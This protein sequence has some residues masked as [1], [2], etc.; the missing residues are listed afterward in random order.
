MR[1]FTMRVL[2]FSIAIVIGIYEGILFF[3]FG[4]F[5]P[6]GTLSIQVRHIHEQARSELGLP[7]QILIGMS[8]GAV[9][10]LEHEEQQALGI[11]DPNTPLHCVYALW[12]ISSDDHGSVEL[13]KNLWRAEA[14]AQRT[15][16]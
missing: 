16:R 15:Q 13:A 5:S 12:K 2:L 3:K 11:P 1:G 9:E 7:R 6:C 8:V 14:E 4:T 10:Q